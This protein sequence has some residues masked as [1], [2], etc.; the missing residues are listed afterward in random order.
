[1]HR[2][3]AESI[4]KSRSKSFV[5]RFSILT[6]SLVLFL[7]CP[8]AVSGKPS[9][10]LQVKGRYL[11][12][13]CGNRLLIRGVEQGLWWAESQAA[14]VDHIAATGAN[15]MRVIVNHPAMTW[16][17]VDDLF[18]KI[19]G[20]QMIFYWSIYDVPP[21][22]GLTGY[23]DINYWNLPEVKALYQKYKKWIIVDAMQEWNGADADWAPAAIARIQTL[24]GWGYDCPLDVITGM[25]GRKLPLILT[26][27]TEIEAADPLHATIFGWQAYWFIEDNPEWGT[28]YWTYQSEFGMSLYEGIRQASLQNFPVQIGIEK[29]TEAGPDY[30]MDFLGAMA[31]AQQYQVG[32]LWWCWGFTGHQG[33]TS[34][35]EARIFTD[36]GEQVAITDP[37]SIANTAVKACGH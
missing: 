2:R 31:S 28:D 3:A 35:A 22:L 19:T 33:M 9:Q 6:I 13:T 29:Y 21:G 26:H 36:Y 23:T 1:M 30:Y 32:W 11:L 14:V 27:G 18:A 17:D 12:D 37:N 16:Q 25:C 5:F 10:T 4:N 8:L 34:D 24:R 20:H 7:S 15:A